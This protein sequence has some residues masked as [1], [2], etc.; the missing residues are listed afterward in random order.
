MT[1]NNTNMRYISFTAIALLALAL[2]S[3]CNS[4]DFQ[5]ESYPED[6]LWDTGSIIFRPTGGTQT[7]SF[8]AQED[9][10]FEN[11][12]EWITLSQS[13]GKEGVQEITVSSYLNSSGSDRSAVLYYT[14]KGSE[15]VKE[16]LV[17]QEAP[18]FNVSLE[19]A[20]DYRMTL[21]WYDSD[22]SN[23]R[24]RLFIDSNLDWKINVNEE[25]DFEAF[26]F[27]KTEGL[28]SETLDFFA[29][30]NN[31]G[32]E[33]IEITFTLDAYMDSTYMDTIGSLVNSYSYIITQDNLRFLLNNANSDVDISIDELNK[34]IENGTVTVDCQLPWHVEGS[35]GWVKLDNEQGKENVISTINVKADGVNPSLEDRTREILLVAEGQGGKAVR[36]LNVT[37]R[38]FIFELDCDGGELENT[39]GSVRTANINASGPWTTVS[40]PQGLTMDPKEGNAGTTTVRISTSTL[41]LDETGKEYKLKLKNTLNNLVIEPVLLQKEYVLD[42][43]PDEQLEDIPTLSTEAYPVQIICSG[44]WTLSSSSNWIHFSKTSGTGNTTVMVNASSANPD[45][46]SDRTAAIVLTSETHKKAGKNLSRQFQVMQRKFTFEISPDTK[47]LSAYDLDQNLNLDIECSGNWEITSCPSW[48]VPE[49]RTGKYDRVLSFRVNPNYDLTAERSGQVSVKCTQINKEHSFTVTQHKFQFSLSNSSTVSFNPVNNEAFTIELITEKNAGW[50]V[51]TDSSSWLNIQGSTRGT[52]PSTFVLV[53]HDNTTSKKRTGKITVTNSETSTSKTISVEQK[54]YEFEASGS[55]YNNCG[56]VDAASYSFNITCSGDWAVENSSNWLS[57]D[58]KGGSGNGR[59]T[60]SVA[61]NIET[62]QRQGT[63]YIYSTLHGKNDSDFSKKISITQRGYEFDSTPVSQNLEAVVG[64]GKSI[65]IYFTC[66]GSWSVNG[67]PNWIT[68]TPFSGSGD[69]RV[70]LVPTNNSMP[71]ERKAQI[72]IVSSD[73]SSFKKEVTITQKGYV[74]SVNNTALKFGKAAGSQTV[75]IMCE[76][77]WTAATSDNWI[78]LSTNQGVGNG[79]LSISVATNKS[80]KERTGKVVVTSEAG[81]TITISVTQSKK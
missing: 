65:D 3:S 11:V 10:S 72:T 18:V 24:K 31:L 70:S 26:S 48:L 69:G 29:K 55:A 36:R 39:I 66:S 62:S 53:P 57:I 21:N 14:P 67:C 25:Q 5:R 35:T 40:V 23:V 1:D 63:V 44:D 59:T 68:C 58:K 42:M 22:E 71:G 52:G 34:S 77:T 45:Y 73:N 56:P 4:Y 51:S 54:R 61:K 43:I 27:T 2:V 76:S 13:K 32:E 60:I 16:I 37:Q 41:N 28:G 20:E 33:P 6:V 38:R 80:K 81:S 7:I 19:D 15:D 78:T 46:D 74:F 12:P 49:T 75:S 17:A 79:S 30:K 64:A 47:E 8:F 9:W 50:T